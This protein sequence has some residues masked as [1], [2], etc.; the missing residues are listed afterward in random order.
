MPWAV[1][2]GPTIADAPRRPMA[3][4]NGFDGGITGLRLAAPPTAL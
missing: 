4:I 1:K 3:S 2:P